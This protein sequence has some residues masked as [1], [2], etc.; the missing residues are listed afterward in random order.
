MADFKTQIAGYTGILAGTDAT[1]ST[2]E[3]TEFLVDGVIDVTRR[4]IQAKPQEAFKFQW[5]LL[6]FK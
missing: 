2:A 6:G 5:M 4:C 3:C 1:V